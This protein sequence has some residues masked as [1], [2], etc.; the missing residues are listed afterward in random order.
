MKTK[1]MNNPAFTLI[2][3]LVV[4]AIIG[5]LAAIMLPSIAKAM[6]KGRLTRAMANGRSIYLAVMESVLSQQNGASFPAKGESEEG[7]FPTST[8]YFRYLITNEI[9]NTDYTIFAEE[10]MQPYKGMEPDEFKA[11][12]NAW[13]IT[14]G[15]RSGSNEKT[16]FLF[17]KNL[18]IS[19]LEKR[20]TLRDFMKE[21][22]L[23][24]GRN[25]LVVIFKGGA[26]TMLR[27]TEITWQNF[28]PTG[29]SNDVLQAM[30]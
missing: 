11:D 8:D 26:G 18:Q 13:C 5:V 1:T 10:G 27:N 2:E 20:N 14:A 9:M 15:L 22:A 24:F 29:A 17:T 30:E 6:E 23:P 4:I 7:G 16:P 19:T 3:L 12:H 25:G 21:D 28:N